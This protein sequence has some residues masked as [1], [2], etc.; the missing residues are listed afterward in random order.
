MTHVH[1]QRV[2]LESGGMKL[3]A[4]HARRVIPRGSHH[5]PLATV[6]QLGHGDL[7]AGEA[8]LH[9]MF[10]MA[11]PRAVHPHAL[12]ELGN[13]SLATGRKVLERFL[14]GAV[15]PPDQMSEPEPEPERHAR[16]GKV[17][18]ERVPRAIPQPDGHSGHLNAR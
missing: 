14:D 16:G 15:A 10:V 12:R 17:Y 11:A 2:P 5:V 9:Q 4:E 18:Y 1:Y 8:L 6:R 7:E 3:L 13:G